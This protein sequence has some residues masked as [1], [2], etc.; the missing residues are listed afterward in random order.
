M[1]AWQ[2]RSYGSAD[3]LMPVQLPD[4]QPLEG[5][6][7]IEVRA[8]GINRSE[9][10]TRQGHS[11]D[12]VTLPRVLGIECVGVVLD[13][14]GTD[15]QKDQ[16]VAACMGNMGRSYDGGYAEKTLI[17]RDHVF[18][19]DVDLDWTTFG[20]IPETYL[21]AWGAIHEAIDLKPNTSLLIRGGTSAAGMACLSI[22]KGM[23]CEVFTTT[24]SEEKA[25]LLVEMGADHVLID[26][27]NGVQ[28]DIKK[29]LPEGVAGA[30]DFVGL[31][32][33]IMDCLRSTK[34]KGTVCMVGFLGDTWDYRFFPWMPSTVKL[35]LYSS[36]TLT[37]VYATPALQHIVDQVS[38]G[39]YKPNIDEVFAFDDLPL[40][41]R[42]MEQNRAAGKLVVLAQ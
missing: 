34:P 42:K 5:S 38:A 8:F 31:Q 11:G 26:G 13:G 4:P 22:A 36:E 19:I 29:I 20:A 10:Y 33:T 21:T 17:P 14:G 32:S 39:I 2:I 40:A 16:K 28:A 24:R 37:T 30:I 41:H 3:V 25:A 9:L 18:P 1:K 23:G 35:T 7:L 15:L 6:V 27:P 12:A